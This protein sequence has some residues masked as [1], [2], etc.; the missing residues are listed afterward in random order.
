MAANSRITTSD[1]AIDGASGRELMWEDIFAE[2]RARSASDAATW[3]PKTATC[4]LSVQSVKSVHPMK[5]A[6]TTAITAPTAMSAC[7]RLVAMA[8]SFGRVGSFG[9]VISMVL[10]PLLP[11]ARRSGYGIRPVRGYNAGG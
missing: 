1:S 2:T 7:R 5:A 9:T 8:G 3:L 6:A 10:I 4:R 11:A